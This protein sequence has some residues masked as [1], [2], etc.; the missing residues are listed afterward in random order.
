[1]ISHYLVRQ[2]IPVQIECVRALTPEM[3]RGKNLIVVASMRYRSL[4]KHMNLPRE[5]IFDGRGEGSIVNVHR[6]PGEAAYYANSRG[7]GFATS[8]AMVSVWAGDSPRRRMIELSGSHSWSTL[9]AVEYLASRKGAREL[10]RLFRSE[11]RPEPTSFQVL[12]EAERR[13]GRVESIRYVTHRVL[14]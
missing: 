13:G 2:G 10:A 11:G 3:I 5:F 9:A 14:E 6:R 7:P 8:Y 1:M 12:L 4:L